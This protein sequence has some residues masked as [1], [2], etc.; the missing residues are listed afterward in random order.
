MANRTR[1]ARGGL[2]LNRTLGQSPRHRSLT[3]AA[4]QN[5]LFLLEEKIGK[6]NSG[7]DNGI[8]TRVSWLEA[9]RT[10][11]VLYPRII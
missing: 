11:T 2:K 5:T 8:R 10:T 9:K 1:G 6:S 7:A 3:L 4:K